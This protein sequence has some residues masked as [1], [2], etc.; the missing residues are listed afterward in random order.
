[1]ADALIGEHWP[2]VQRLAAAVTEKQ[3]FTGNG[4]FSG[5]EIRDL[6]GGNGRNGNSER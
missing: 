2:K 6:L 1:M 3:K 4:R 5:A